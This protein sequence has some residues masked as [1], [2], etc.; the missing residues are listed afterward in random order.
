MQSDLTTL[1]DPISSGANYKVEP[2][3]KLVVLNAVA[4][5]I[6]FIVVGLSNFGVWGRTNADLSD[7]IPTL[8]TPIGYAFSIWGVIFISETIFVVWQSLPKKQKK[9][10]SP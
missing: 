3:M 6:N 9:S 5:A 1:L 7:S 2:N 8:V 10:I 4:F